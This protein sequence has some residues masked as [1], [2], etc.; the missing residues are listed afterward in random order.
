MLDYYS[1]LN[2]PSIPKDIAATAG[3]VLGE[4]SK[5]YNP[6][7]G[8]IFKDSSVESSADYYRCCLAQ[9]CID[10][11]I[12]HIPETGNEQCVFGY[13][14]IVGSQDTSGTMFVHTDG[15]QRGIYVLSYI[16]DTG[17]DHD[18]TTHWWKEQD[19]PKHR[20]PHTFCLDHRPLDELASVVF[21]PNT[22]HALDASILHNVSGIKSSRIAVTVGFNNKDL[23]DQIVTK[24]QFK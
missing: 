18:V 10:W 17:S 23:I 3:N 14:R 11:I 4:N 5:P 7:L 6:P 13:Q 9:E 24:Y 8:L 21:P 1:I 16:L 20:P 22:W 19:Q 12:E 2:I 15:R